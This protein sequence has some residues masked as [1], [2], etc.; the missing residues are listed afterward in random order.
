MGPDPVI[1]TTPRLQDGPQLTM[2]IHFH[3]TA[4]RLS[5]LRARHPRLV[6]LPGAAADRRHLRLARWVSPPL[7]GPSRS[8]RNARP[9]RWD[10]GRLRCAAAPQFAFPERR[11]SSLWERPRPHESY[12]LSRSSSVAPAAPPPSPAICTPWATEAVDRGR[13]TMAAGTQRTRDTPRRLDASASIALNRGEVAAARRS[14]ARSSRTRL[15]VEDDGSGRR[16][17]RSRNFWGRGPSDTTAHRGES[18]RRSEPTTA[19]AIRGAPTPGRRTAPSSGNG[20]EASS[21]ST[22]RW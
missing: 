6:M 20:A 19:S 15:Q 2:A 5:C 22:K 11:R 16:R 13:E 9:R 14:R 8:S 1:W 4:R 10:L 7:C 18:G 3:A 21:G 17:R 12:A